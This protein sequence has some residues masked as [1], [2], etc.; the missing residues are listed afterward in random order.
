ML[1]QHKE[2]ILFVFVVTILIGLGAF[3]AHRGIG[4]ELFS[5]DQQDLSEFSYAEEKEDQQAS[6]GAHSSGAVSSQPKEDTGREK[7]QEDKKI[8]LCYVHIDGAVLHPGVYGVQTGE[9]V[10][11][12]IK[13]AGGLTED[14]NLDSVNLAMKVTDEMKIVIPDCNSSSDE[15]GLESTW[16]H[17][18]DQSKNPTRDQNVP[19]QNEDAFTVNINQAT[20]EE[21]M[22]LPSIGPSRAEEIINYRSDHPFKTIEEI[23]NI[24]GIGEKTFEK[25]KH[26]LRTE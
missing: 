24:S 23:K 22:S 14:A 21:L 26:R 6:E 3:Q 20:K 10:S 12:V 18:P 7:D 2:K 1:S 17:V 5:S 25:L 11:D 13:Q 16:V 19:G 4:K 15:N 9:R 8:S